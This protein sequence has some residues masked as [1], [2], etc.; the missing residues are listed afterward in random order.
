MLDL[1]IIGAP[2]CATS[3]LF[4]WLT[5]HPRISGPEDRKELFF[6]MDDEHPLIRRPN[7]H[8]E[9]LKVY[10][11]LFPECADYLIEATTHYLYQKTARK[12]LLRMN[13]SPLILVI[14]RDPSERVWSSFQYSKNNKAKISSDL[15]FSQYVRW[16]LSGEEKRIRRFITGSSYVLERE[17]D[18]S[19][20]VKYLDYWQNE[21]IDDKIKV[22]SFEEIV[23]DPKSVCK[24][25]AAK[26]GACTEIYENINFSKRNAT[27]SVRSR[28]LHKVA[29]KTGEILPSSRI[30]S[31][32]KKIY[33]SFFTRDAG[34]S[35]TA[36]DEEALLCLRKYFDP[37]NN[38]LAKEF[39]IDISNW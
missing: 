35:K 14:V 8:T 2:K 33:T 21:N 39:D 19:K 38:Q 17:I 1:C 5:A 26:I 25:I 23:R 6:F 31:K 20:Y 37:Y 11:N 16:V 10:R 34:P 3:S 27:Y 4:R 29:K 13:P 15:T 28:L 24:N 18:H 12:Y 36:E 7:V 9:S 32:A 22:I 30:K